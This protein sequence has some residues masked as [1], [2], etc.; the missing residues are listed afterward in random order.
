M[1]GMKFD[2]IKAS[3]DEIFKKVAAPS[4]GPTKK[5]KKVV[6]VA[7]QKNEE[8]SGNMYASLDMIMKEQKKST[9]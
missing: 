4:S 2:Y 7:E 1:G 6:V 9:K 8:G 5:P 3:E